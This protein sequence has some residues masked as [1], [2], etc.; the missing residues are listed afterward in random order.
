MLPGNGFSCV[1]FKGSLEFPRPCSATHIGPYAGN[2]SA[3]ASRSTNTNSMTTWRRKDL[4]LMPPKQ[5]EWHFGPKKKGCL[6]IASIFLMCFIAVSKCGDML[7][8]LNNWCSRRTTN[9]CYFFWSRYKR[10]LLVSMSL[11]KPFWWGP[12][13]LHNRHSMSTMEL[14]ISSFYN[15]RQICG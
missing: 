1:F 15:K 5:A 4:H 9:F 10:D 8:A 6:Y 12:Q 7:I 11:K 3:S 13:P 2:F 14:I